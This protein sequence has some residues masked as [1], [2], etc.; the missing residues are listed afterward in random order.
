MNRRAISKM[1]GVKL[2]PVSGEMTRTA[3]KMLDTEMEYIDYL[4]NRKKFFV[5]TQ[6][7]QQRVTIGKAKAERDADGKDKKKNRFRLRKRLKPKKKVRFKNKGKGTKIGRF[8]RNVRAGVKRL[9]GAPSLGKKSIYGTKLPKWMNP[10]NIGKFKDNIVG[11]ANRLGQGIG[12]QINKGKNFVVDKAKVARQFVG[13]KVKQGVNLGKKGLGAIR[14]TWKNRGTIL[15]ATEDV[16]K[17]VQKS[18]MFKNVGK[19]LGKGSGRAIPV[20][21]MA[22]SANDIAR[23]NK[24]GGWKGWVGSSLAAMDFA[25]DATTLATA[26]ASVTGVG[27]AI[28][29]IAA[30]VSQI[31]GWGL[32]IFEL[33][34]VL[35]GQDPYAA[36]NEETGEYDGESKKG[37]L[38]AEGGEVTRPTKAIIGEGGEGELV[39]PHSKM[40]NVMSSLFKEVGAMMLGVTKGFLGT[41]P[42]PSTESQ[43]IA[44]EASKLGGLFP[45]GEIPKVFSG[46]KVTDKLASFVKNNAT[47]AL[48][49]SNPIIGILNAVFNKPAQAETITETLSTTNT[50]T[51]T[52]QQVSASSVGSF[53]ITDYYGST[54]GRSKPHGGVDVGTP[55][56]T[57]VGFAEDGEILASGRYGGYG[58]LMDVWLP[59]SGIQMRIAHLSQFIKKSGEFFAGEVLA[60]TG[61]AK[62]DPGAGSST[63]P[64]LHFEFD[65][66]KDSTRYGGAGDPLPYAH[67][68]KLGNVVPPSSDGDG[69]PS[70]AASYGHPLQYTVKW[71][72]SNG[73]MGGPSFSPAKASGLEPNRSG[74]NSMTK[75][76]TVILPIPL[77]QIIPVPVTQVVHKKVERKPVFGLNNFSG[78]Y[79]EL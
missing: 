78:K 52:T 7:Q 50:T 2:L 47:R 69:G 66:K 13:D 11:K 5:M 42:T 8:V 35:S 9:G 28:P 76:A 40:G 20:A 43:K 45:G 16:I 58:N 61:G 6:I 64:H 22:L 60:K 31:A 21:S 65:T 48:T 57:P 15:S 62:G 53:N 3:K 75:V 34:Q 54:E 74:M 19:V 30:T 79:G 17:K 68:I 25:A 36:F 67:L 23:Y 49:A 63:G 70:L 56:G 29:G 73:S 41:L 72:T 33:L 39:I 1:L 59:S 55:V 18:K 32:T 26:P 44:S 27:A 24:M 46:T 37:F 12:N 77:Q 10:K 14:S 71:P 38:F 51:D 4:R